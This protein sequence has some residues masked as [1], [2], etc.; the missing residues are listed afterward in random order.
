[1]FKTHE[2]TVHIGK[3]SSGAPIVAIGFGEGGSQSINIHQL[4]QK[5][6][7]QASELSV[8]Y[9]RIAELQALGFRKVLL[10][11]RAMEVLGEIAER[12]GYTSVGKLIKSVPPTGASR[13]DLAGPCKAEDNKHSLEVWLDACLQKLIHGK[14]NDLQRV[15]RDCATQTECNS[16]HAHAQTE[17]EAL[18]VTPDD[19]VHKSWSVPTKRH[20]YWHAKRASYWPGLFSKQRA[21]SDVMN[22]GNASEKSVSLPKLR[23][24]LKASVNADQRKSISP[25]V[26]ALDGGESRVV[27]T[28][29]VE[30]AINGGATPDADT[31]SR[32]PSV[33]PVPTDFTGRRTS[34]AATK[35]ME[36]DVPLDILL[37]RQQRIRRNSLAQAPVIPASS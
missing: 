4:T 9:Q 29:A 18:S 17:T 23:D 20:S 37:K 14:R 13:T 1:M 16:A 22:T 11:E 26:V 12:S 24:V 30:N 32:R 21:V 15:R 28:P 2:G 3:A 7:D 5:L 27:P 25:D 31:R 10:F 33:L 35:N 19:D 6:E 36:A 34:A 8:A